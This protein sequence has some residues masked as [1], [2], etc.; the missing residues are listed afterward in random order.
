MEK[1]LFKPKATTKPLK[2]I[3][4]YALAIVAKREHSVAELTRKLRT[5]GYGKAETEALV[6]DFKGRN[7][8]NDARFASARARTRAEHSKWGEG[9]IKQE[10]ALS[11]VDKGLAASALGEVSEH[12]DW[13]AAATKLVKRRFPKPLPERN[14]ADPALTGVEFMKELQKEKAK[15]VNFLLRRGF[16]MGQAVTALGLSQDEDYTE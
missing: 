13:L 7:Y 12:H 16:S 6:A 11:G 8:V 1:Q 10:L 5:K 14:D 9:R 15:R 2:P 4:D 3:A